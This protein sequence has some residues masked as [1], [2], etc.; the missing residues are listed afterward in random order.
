MCGVVGAA[1]G[2]MVG[3]LKCTV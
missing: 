1:Q 3:K 2:E